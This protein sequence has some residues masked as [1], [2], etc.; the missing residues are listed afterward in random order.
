MDKI[1]FYSNFAEYGSNLA[2]FAYKI[3]F[4]GSNSNQMELNDLIS[5]NAYSKS[6]EFS[7]IDFDNQTMALNN[8][9]QILISP[10]NNSEASIVGINSALLR[11]GVAS[12]DNFIAIAKPGST[13]VQLKVSSKALD[14]FKINQVYKVSSNNIM[15]ANFRF[16][17]PGEANLQD[18]KWTEWPPGTYSLVWN[19]TQCNQCPANAEWLGGNKISI[20]AGY[21]R[22]SLNTSTIVKWI[23]A[24]AWAGGFVEQD[25]GP[26]NWSTGYTGILWDLCQVENGIKYEKVSDTVWSK[27]PSPILNAIRVIGL[28]L[29]VFAFIA[30]TIVLNIRKTN[31]SQLSVLL[32]ILT[33]YLQIVSSLLSFNMKYPTMISNL[34][35]PFN[36]MGSSEV[37]L[38]FDCFATDFNIQGPFP[39]NKMFKIFLAALLPLILLIIFFAIWVILQKLWP[40]FV[41]DLKRNITISFISIVFL[42]HPRLVQN[43][44][45]IFEWVTIDNGDSRAK[46][47][48]DYQ[49]YSSTHIKWILAIAFP[50][51]IIWVFG[52]PLIALVLLFKNYRKKNDNKIKQYFLILYQGLKP[53]MFYW[54]FVNTFIKSIIL[55]IFIALS[56]LDQN[57]KIILSAIFMFIV[58]RL[59]LKISPYMDK[60]NNILEVKAMIASLITMIAGIV[61]VQDTSV[62]FIDTVLLLFVLAINAWF[63]SE[64][65][66]LFSSC[67]QENYRVFTYVR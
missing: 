45:G 34:F 26:I 46:V 41:L 61:F 5:G 55:L 33:N 4:N 24:D 37:F 2:S 22:K 15:Y 48:L 19:S 9:N 44:I 51:L 14:L 28:S 16:W 43:S 58:I 1:S 18:N 7:L 17:K 3:V 8:I 52:M 29:L 32:R 31:E 13:N 64:W 47:C 65:I 35:T 11:N 60:R 39:S 59:E 66:Y 49:C 62:G 42:L 40:R 20:D 27:C 30:W 67:M 57:V 21:W 54:E 50:I 56:V 6:I 12:F 25:F 36:Q 63:L 38:S 23:N 10:I 53:N